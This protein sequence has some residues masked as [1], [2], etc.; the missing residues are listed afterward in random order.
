MRYLAYGLSLQ[1]E[2][3][4]PISHALYK[5]E[6]GSSDEKTG[7]DFRTEASGLRQDTYDV[8]EPRSSALRWAV[9]RMG[10]VRRPWKAQATG[11]VTMT[12]YPEM[13][14]C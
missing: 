8:P 3:N 10:I 7:T 11:E 12:D 1:V 5:S 2:D 13:G 6:R 4:I 9:V 14:L